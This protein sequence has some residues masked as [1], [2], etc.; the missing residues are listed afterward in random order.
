MD[1]VTE[2]DYYFDVGNI[3]LGERL[4]DKRFHWG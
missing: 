4:L 1:T 3:A 2:D